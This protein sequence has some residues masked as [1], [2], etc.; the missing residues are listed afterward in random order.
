MFRVCIKAQAPECCTPPCWPS[1]AMTWSPIPHFTYRYSW[2]WVIGLV[3]GFWFG[4][5]HKHWTMPRLGSDILPA[6]QVM[7][8]L[9]RASR[10]RF[11]VKSWPPCT[12]PLSNLP[13]RDSPGSI[14]LL[15]ACGVTL[16]LLALPLPAGQ[17]AMAA[18]SG[19][20]RR[21]WAGRPRAG[22]IQS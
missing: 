2:Q 6:T 21:M 3:Q 16:L 8:R 22:P 5:H 13:L 20:S 7:S 9:Y 1:W 12:F 11:W 19:A 10:G 4:E 18:D 15:V 14:F 17:S